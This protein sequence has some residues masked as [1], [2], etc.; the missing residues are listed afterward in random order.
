[1]L[2]SDGW[3]LRP[4][5]MT[6]IDGYG[7]AESVLGGLQHR[8]IFNEIREFRFSRPTGDGNMLPI[9]TRSL[10]LPLRRRYFCSDLGRPV[11]NDDRRHAL[12]EIMARVGA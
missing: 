3:F 4:V 2:I 12:E 7:Q 5:T 6:L 11:P 9:L 10:I 1:M 8:N